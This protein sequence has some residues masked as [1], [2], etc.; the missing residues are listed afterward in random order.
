MRALFVW[1]LALARPRD[2][3]ARPARPALVLALALG[4]V[5]LA[6]LALA[7]PGSPCSRP[8]SSWLANRRLDVLLIM[9]R[10]LDTY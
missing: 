4:L 5:W 3:P 1:A 7:R 2:R 10:R 8:G 9:N 6:L